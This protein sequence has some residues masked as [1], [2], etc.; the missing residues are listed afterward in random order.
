MAQGK[1]DTK[2]RMFD[3]EKVAVIFVLGGPGAGSLFTWFRPLFLIMLCFFFQVK[4]LSAPDL[5]RIMVSYI[6]LVCGST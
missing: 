3:H 6:S 1:G 2:M 4:E 5:L